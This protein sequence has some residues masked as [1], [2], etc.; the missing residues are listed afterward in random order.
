MD[1]SQGWTPKILIPDASG[2][3]A[4]ILITYDVPILAAPVAKP[5]LTLVKTALFRSHPP[6]P[7]ST[8]TVTT[9]SPTTSPLLPFLLPLASKLTL[10]PQTIFTKERARTAGTIEAALVTLLQIFFST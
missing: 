3:V 10:P 5:H 2:K 8:L 1:L 6:L 7:K 9:P 4:E